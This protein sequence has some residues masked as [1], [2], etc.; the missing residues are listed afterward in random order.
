MNNE[1]GW[2]TR[3]K[4]EATIQKRLIQMLNELEAGDVYMKMAYRPK[5]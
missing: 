5:M 4:R 2:I 3:A 1:I